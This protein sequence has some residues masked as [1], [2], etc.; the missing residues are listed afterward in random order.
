M[1]V[2]GGADDAVFRVKERVGALDDVTTAVVL[3]RREIAKSLRLFGIQIADGDAAEQRNDCVAVAVKVNGRRS[4]RVGF[5]IGNIDLRI[6]AKRQDFIRRVG[7]VAVVVNVGVALC[8]I[9]VFIDT[10]GIHGLYRQGG[11]CRGVCIRC[12]HVGRLLRTAGRQCQ[13]QH[14]GQQKGWYRTL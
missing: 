7:I 6:D 5:F 2:A 3:L 4:V 13:A 9:G 12:K 14:T 8:H 11:A 10:L 1:V